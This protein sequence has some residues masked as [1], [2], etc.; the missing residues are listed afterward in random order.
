MKKLRIRWR[1][2]T[3]D[4]FLARHGEQITADQIFLPTA[5]PLEPG[6][7]VKFELLLDDRSPFLAGTGTISKTQ[8]DAWSDRPGMLLR[9]DQLSDE[10]AQFVSQLLDRVGAGEVD[11]S[12]LEEDDELADGE[13]T[14]PDAQPIGF[15]G[16]KKRP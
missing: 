7:E 14:R 2:A 5:A 9:F 15:R 6:T 12:S 10:H 4:E 11:L 8:D 16:R 3:V 13:D 1:V